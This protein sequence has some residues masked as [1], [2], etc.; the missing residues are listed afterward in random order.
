VS[1]QSSEISVVIPGWNP[2]ETV[3]FPLELIPECF[4]EQG[5]RFHC[6]CN[7]GVEC[8]DLLILTEFEEDDYD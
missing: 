7:V 6:K 2:E 3:V 5:K 1:I 8:S 4:H